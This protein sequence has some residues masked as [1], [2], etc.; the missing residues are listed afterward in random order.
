MRKTK[1]EVRANIIIYT[2]TGKAIW[3]AVDDWRNKTTD[4]ADSNGIA[5]IDP[6]NVRLVEFGV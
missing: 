3:L 5:E 6:T 4:K 2:D 1:I